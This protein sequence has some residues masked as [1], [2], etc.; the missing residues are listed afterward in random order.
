[1]VFENKRGQGMS[2]NTIILLILGVVVLVVLIFGFTTGWKAFKNIANP[3]NVDDIREDCKAV[4]GLNEEFSFC[5]GE[6]ILR[7]N[8]EDFEVKTSCAVL[9]SS[10]DFIRYKIESCPSVKCE[11]KCEEIRV[12]D[13]TGVKVDV[14]VEG[15]YDVSALANDLGP[16]EKCIIN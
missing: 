10:P 12:D 1:M 13:E 11:M 16:S 6:R 9:A 5:S 2:T 8:E 14:D 7:V 3:T 4:C 15:G